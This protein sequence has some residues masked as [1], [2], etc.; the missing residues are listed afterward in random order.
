MILKERLGLTEG[1]HRTHRVIPFSVEE[2]TR[3]LRVEFSF[4]PRDIP[5]GELLDSKIDEEASGLSPGMKGKIREMV[6]AMG[7]GLTNQISLSLIGP[8]GYIGCAHQLTPELDIR[9]G[10]EGTSPGFFPGRPDPGEWKAVLSMDCL[11][12]P[13][14]AELTVWGVGE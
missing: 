7:M 11:Y 9:L 8:K 2:G 13:V 1:D 3:E 5:D 6:R 12:R 14:E 4:S 10:E